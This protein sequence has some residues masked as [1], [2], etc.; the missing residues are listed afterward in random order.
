MD[1]LGPYE[2]NQIYCGECSELM[3]GLPADSI[4][5][6]ITSP[7]YDGLRAYNGYTFDF[8]AIARQLY[9]ITQP[10]GVGIWVVADEPSGGR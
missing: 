7:P 8:E 10:G 9:R 4:P 6:W 5:M 3:V 1:R 2:L